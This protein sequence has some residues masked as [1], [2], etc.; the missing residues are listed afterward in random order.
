MERISNLVGPR[1]GKTNYLVGLQSL[2]STCAAS[3]LARDISVAVT[4]I[5]ASTQRAISEEGFSGLWWAQAAAALLQSLGE[6]CRESAAPPLDTSLLELSCWRAFHPEVNS[7][8]C[9]KDSI[10]NSCL[11]EICDYIGASL[12][13]KPLWYRL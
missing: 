5:S 1:E 4:K 3:C 2:P 11:A 13:Q 10:L 7:Y 12:R 9:N 8:I 6:S